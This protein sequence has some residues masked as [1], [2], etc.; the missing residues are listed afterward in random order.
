MLALFYG[1]LL[2]LQAQDLV[3]KKIPFGKNLEYTYYHYYSEFGRNASYETEKFLVLVTD[4]V[5]D[6]NKYD[7]W[8]V[9]RLTLGDTS[10][11]TYITKYENNRLIDISG[12]VIF[13][14]NLKKDDS[15]NH[16]QIVKEVSEY[17]GLKRIIG[18]T[19]YF[20]TYY[21]DWVEAVGSTYS[22]LWPYE[23]FSE[24]NFSWLLSFKSDGQ[25]LFKEEM[26]NYDVDT[27][28]HYCY[29]NDSDYDTFDFF[30]PSEISL[31][32]N[33]QILD[34]IQLTYKLNSLKNIQ[35]SRVDML[36]Y[37]LTSDS[38]G[39]VILPKEGKLGDV[40]MSI[41]NYNCHP[42][43]LVYDRVKISIIN[44]LSIQNKKYVD[45]LIVPNPFQSTLSIN[46]LEKA[47]N[48]SIF[49]ITGRL[50]FAG[51]I[52]VNQVLPVEYLPKGMYIALITDANG[53]QRL[54]FLKD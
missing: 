27:M 1:G 50:H 16:F 45:Y 23:G 43:P 29:Y 21:V 3:T 10:K 5:I 25:E 14:F 18:G 52:D 40:D 19:T 54:R 31:D 26:F 15:I 28:T 36:E 7:V 17:N 9:T 8:N 47:S 20:S 4:T 35:L 13:D 37:Y 44:N 22:F 11:R 30:I 38:L 42:L 34:T 41:T 39:I 33:S 49:D 53:S 2:G 48:I 6:T 46:G 24:M 51:M 12:L 32:C